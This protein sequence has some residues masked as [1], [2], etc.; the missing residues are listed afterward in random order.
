MPFFA[1]LVPSRRFL[2]V[3]TLLF[4][5]L[6]PGCG[7]EGETNGRDPSSRGPETPEISFGPKDGHDLSPTELDR[8]APGTMAPDFTLRSLTG[9]SHTLSQYRGRKNVILV[10]YR[11]HW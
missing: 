11:G 3:L 8:V 7:G 10:F 6:L 2:T 1:A 5:A 9:E 4:P